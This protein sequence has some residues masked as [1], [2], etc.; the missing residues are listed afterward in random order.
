MRFLFLFIYSFNLFICFL[1]Y[2]FFNEVIKLYIIHIKFNIYI[3]VFASTT[4]ECTAA[5]L[6]LLCPDPAASP[7][8]LAEPSSQR[9]LHTLQ[10]FCC[11]RCL[12]CWIAALVRW[13]HWPSWLADCS[14][15]NSNSGWL[16]WPCLAGWFHSPMKTLPYIHRLT[17]IIVYMHNL[18]KLCLIK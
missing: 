8:S 2:S 6:W 4:F 5:T 10:C 1:I 9:C 16:L 7:F 12:G 13:S 3:Y 15:S 17:C 14:I 11:L 18:V